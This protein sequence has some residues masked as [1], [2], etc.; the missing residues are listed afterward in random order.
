MFSRKAAKRA[1]TSR[2]TKRGLLTRTMQLESL[3]RRQ[4]LAADLGVIDEGL[5]GALFGTLQTHVNRDVL[6]AEAPL[7]GSQLAES[8]A[9]QFLTA[10]ERDLADLELESGSVRIADVEAAISNALAGKIGAAG[11][12][13]E[14]TDGDSEIRFK[15]PIQFTQSAKVNADLGLGEN[16]NVDILLGNEDKVN[17]NVDVTL[18]LE[19]GVREK[20]DG[21]T[22]FFVVTDNANELRIIVDAD[23]MQDF[24]GGTGRMGVFIADFDAGQEASSFQG[25]YFVDISGGGADGLSMDELGE[26]SV[27]GLLNGEATIHLDAAGSFLPTIEGMN[28]DSLFNLGVTTQVRIEYDFVDAS[29]N[30]VDSTGKQTRVLG[31]APEIHYENNRLDLGTLFRDFIDPVLSGIRDVIMPTKPVVNFLTDPLPVIGEFTDLTFFDAAQKAI[32]AMPNSARKVETQRS[33]DRAETVV[34]LMNRLIDYRTPGSEDLNDATKGLGSVAMK[35]QHVFESDDA[36]DQREKQ[37]QKVKQ[38]I[39]DRDFSFTKP[40]DADKEPESIKKFQADFQGD[41]SF[42]LLT[43]ASAI[44]GLLAGDASTSLFAAELNFEIDF[45]KFEYTVPLAPLAFLVNGEFRFELEAGVDLGFGFD[46]QGVSDFTWSLDFSSQENFELSKSQNEHFLD[47]GFYIDDNNPNQIVDGSNVSRIVGENTEQPEAYM[48]AKA[49]IGGSVG[50]DSKVFAAKAGILGTLAID[51]NVDLNDL[52]DTLPPTEWV[53]PFTPTRPSNASDWTYDGHVRMDE[54]SEMID[55][56][57]ASIV[58]ATGEIIVGLDAIAKV[59][60]GPWELVDFET[61]LSEVSLLNFDIAQANDAHIIE[62][63]D[64]GV[65]L[66]Q[67]LEDGTVQ[68]YAGNLANQRV[69]ITHTA[70]GN[71]SNENFR[72][73]TLRESTRGEGHDVQVI[74]WFKDSSGIR[75]SY[76]QTFENV[77]RVSLDAGDGHDEIIA[78]PSSMVPMQFTGGTGDDVIFGGAANDVLNGGEGRDKI[79]GA[80]GDDTIYGGGGIDTLSGDSGNDVIRGGD[81]NDQ[82]LGGTGNDQVWGDL[83]EDNIRGGD[84]DDQLH[85]GAQNDVIYGEAGAD[86]IWGD[87]GEDWLHG[88]SISNILLL[89]PTKEG[90]GG[91][92]IH[93]GD[94]RDEIRGGWGKDTLMGDSDNDLIYGEAD[95]D[96]IRGG[97]GND[98]LY[99]DAWLDAWGWDDEIHGD[100]GNDTLH[101]GYGDDKLYGNAGRDTLYGEGNSDYLNGGGDGDTLYGDWVINV[102]PFAGNDTLVGDDGN[103]WLYGGPG[104]DRLHGGEHDDVLYGNGGNDTLAGDNGND[105]LYGDNLIDLLGGGADTLSGGNGNDKLHGGPG[106]DSINGDGG[107]DTAYGEGGH[108]TVRGGSGNDLLYGDAV[109]DLVGGNDTIEGGDGADRLHGG[110]G[111]DT[112]RGGA[113]HDTLNGNGGNDRLEGGD[114]N[115]RLYGGLGNDNLY[116][117]SGNDYMHGGWGHDYM[118][119]SSGNDTM[120]GDL[121]NDRM[122]GGSGNDYVHGGW[123]NDSLYGDSGHDRV[124]GDV[125]ADY[126]R[127]GSGNDRLDGGLGGD[128][129][130][131]DSGND[132]LDGGRLL[133]G[134]DFARDYLHGGSG[135]DTIYVQWY[136][137]F[138][139]KK[140][141]TVVSG[142]KQI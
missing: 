84:G 139:W 98:T 137:L 104:N 74:Y 20:A 68:V 3:D 79:N 125:G 65:I 105:T 73:R 102:L 67:R 118:S 82:I 52:P 8:E 109:I 108:D 18:D 48:R 57:P 2:S 45:L 30:V 123:G 36:R 117:G 126:L 4:M 29:T 138:G 59:A 43:E 66:G 51:V 16:S 92:T 85:G 55:Y 80:G 116:G 81:G 53:D 47:R 93:G 23:L 99:G 25:T 9:G 13:V 78:E 110:W 5:Q 60:I 134:R 103:D 31:E 120:Y 50:P 114:H 19:F 15:V 135:Y 64:D 111:N 46:A 90:A 35:Y 32:D 49:S 130:Y 39:K 94:G 89:T 1:T 58:N 42:P 124:Y 54:L 61:N 101:G 83:G 72:V 34:K 41:L 121:G 70:A 33:L 141:E 12:S 97:S 77:T 95:S 11:L 14:G 28:K 112:L 37:Q 24:E 91:D 142:E 128:R 131:G 140:E 6:L 100:S 69:G 7:V 10:I 21:S 127:G 44:A 132:T 122:Y 26:V 17:V 129:I 76:H 87:A 113:G 86:E 71:G 115:D 27:E 88:D 133:G 56:D 22:E 96:L 62:K 107:D 106:N 38:Q 40:S 63:H 75:R 136:W 119:G